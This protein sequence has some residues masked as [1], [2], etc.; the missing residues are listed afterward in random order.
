[1]S[2]SKD[3]EDTIRLVI[4]VIKMINKM[5]LL[6]V[7]NLLK[8]SYHHHD[9]LPPATRQ[10]LALVQISS[11]LTVLN[12]FTVTFFVTASARGQ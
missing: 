10:S 6:F 4:K 11:I 3:D 2:S 12:I 8:V 5:N 1:M 9:T 7:L